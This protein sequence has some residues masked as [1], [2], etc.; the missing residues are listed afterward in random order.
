MSR[1]SRK[2]ERKIKV[3]VEGHSEEN[4]LKEL[5][6]ELSRTKNITVIK[7]PVNLKGGGVS[8]LTINEHL[9]K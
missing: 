5:N 1:K 6:K 3:F 7:K 2:I 9:K 4:Y 8:L